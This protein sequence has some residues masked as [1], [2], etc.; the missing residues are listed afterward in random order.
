MAK[1]PYESLWDDSNF[2]VQLGVL[3]AKA[4]L[5]GDEI[6]QGIIYYPIGAN[7][8][9][10]SGCLDIEILLPAGREKGH[11]VRLRRFSP[12]QPENV[13]TRLYAS[14]ATIFSL[15]VPRGESLRAPHPSRE[16]HERVGTLV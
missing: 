8:I 4:T 9:H 6:G 3:L 14:E 1:F 2:S 10:R 11:H 13:N 12:R 7:L 15:A 5:S 16:L